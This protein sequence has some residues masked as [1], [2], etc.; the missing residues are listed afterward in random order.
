M[1]LRLE[2]FYAAFILDFIYIYLF[3]LDFDIYESRASLD[4]LFTQALKTTYH[5]DHKDAA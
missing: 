2:T 1:R 5:Y 4:G 3:S